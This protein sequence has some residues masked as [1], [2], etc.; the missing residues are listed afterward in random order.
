M[1][2]GR[3]HED[4]ENK[5][6]NYVLGLKFSN[7]LCSGKNLETYDFEVPSCVFDSK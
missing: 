4:R 3:E 7:L 6:K 2:D 1:E 5:M